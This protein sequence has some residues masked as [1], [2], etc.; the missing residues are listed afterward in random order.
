MMICYYQIDNGDDN[1]QVE[2]WALEFDLLLG[3][4]AGLQV[5]V[6]VRKRTGLCGK[7]SQ[8]ADPLPPS[9]Q[10]GNF[11]IFSHFYRFLPFYKPLNWKK[12]R[13]IWSGFGSDPSHPLGNF[14]T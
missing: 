2:A 14:P 13:K 12:Q 8:V 5:R 7:N 6:V 3:D 4:P 9:P 10:F 11:R 1:P